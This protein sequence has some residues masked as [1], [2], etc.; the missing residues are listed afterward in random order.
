M[1]AVVR[2]RLGAVVVA[3]CAITGQAAGPA[4]AEVLAGAA[5]GARPAPGTDTGPTTRD[6]ARGRERVRAQ[7]ARVGRINA[8]LAEADGLLGDLGDQA[9]S[10]VE[11]Y[12]AERVKLDQAKAAYKAAARRSAQARR[13][14]AQV[15][16]DVARMAVGAHRGQGGPPPV[17]TASGGA[18]GPTASGG[19]GRPA[20]S[21][22]AG[23]PAAS[24]GAGGSAASGGAGRPAASGGAGETAGSGTRATT[25]VPV[26]RRRALL[27]REA[28]AQT[29]ADVSELQAR[30]A[31][32]AQEEAVRS[33]ADARQAAVEAVARQ[34][35]AVQRIQQRKAALIAELEAART[36]V[37]ALEEAR[38]AALDQARVAS[39]GTERT[40]SSHQV[41]PTGTSPQQDVPAGTS[42]HAGVPVGA[43]SHQV[44]LA[45]TRLGTGDRALVRGL[46]RGS[47]LGSVAA[48]AALKWLGT[49]YS[50]GGGNETGPTRG[51]AQGAGTV[52][53]DCSGLVT[54]AWGKAGVRLVHYATAQYN[55][56]PHPS[57]GELR[58]GDLVFF[59][60]N[61]ADPSTIHHVGI[62]IGN[63]QMVEAPF[64]GA[65]VRISP[66]FRP[67]YAG[68]T[69]PVAAPLL[70]DRAAPRA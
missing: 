28:A 12:N 47:D 67:D 39:I 58:P 18:G 7:A 16:D 14:L 5:P 25:Q 70:S 42:L 61:P 30:E 22:R 69:R 49:P 40:V 52:G 32:A 62:Y 46:A 13:R 65:R 51:I 50:W 3:T 34:Q 44:A 57:R 54:Y 27:Q 20:A 10:A 59:A 8:E 29:A 1:S 43:S 9:E 24:G 17:A 4:G 41:V 64:T 33:A 37:A 6:V 53:F 68:A 21:G 36:S 48:T 15:R 60:H 66:A 55:A 23:G 19:A 35:E 45:G 31:L 63:G 56:G 11:R 2:R 26:D 38:T